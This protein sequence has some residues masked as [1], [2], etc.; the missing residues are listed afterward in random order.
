MQFRQFT[1]CHRLEVVALTQEV[2]HDAVDLGEAL[3]A[4]MAEGQHEADNFRAG[5]S[6]VHEQPVAA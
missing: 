1:R 3:L 4:D 5:E 2:A 6:I